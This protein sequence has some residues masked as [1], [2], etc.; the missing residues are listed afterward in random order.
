MRNVRKE[1]ISWTLLRFAVHIFIV[2]SIEQKKNSTKAKWVSSL[3]QKFNLVILITNDD[4]TTYVVS[5]FVEFHTIRY[6]IT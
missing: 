2:L 6:Q 1:P 5:L 4:L 3:L